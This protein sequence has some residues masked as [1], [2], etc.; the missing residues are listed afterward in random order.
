MLNG[1]DICIGLP[2]GGLMEEHS[3]SYIYKFPNGMVAPYKTYQ[4]AKE[5]STKLLVKI[6]TNKE[7]SSEFFDI[8]YQE[9]N[10]AK[11]K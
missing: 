7:F 6:A 10:G 1:E 11:Y 9:D 8:S 3:D 2:L 5:I 4:E